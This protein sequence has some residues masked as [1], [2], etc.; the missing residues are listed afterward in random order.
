MAC[1]IGYLIAA[2]INTPAQEPASLSSGKEAAPEIMDDQAMLNSF[3]REAI[4]LKDQGKTVKITQLAR[5]LETCKTS[6]EVAIRVSS[7]GRTLTGEEIFDQCKKGVVVV[8]RLYKCPT[9][10]KFEINAASGIVLSESG[11]IATNRHVISAAN[12]PDPETVLIRTWEGNVFPIKE[13]LASDQKTDLALLQ[14]DGSGFSPLPLA[15]ELPSPGAAVYVI[16]H[17]EKHFYEMTAGIVSRHFMK[18]TAGNIKT[19]RM[20]IT[21]DFGGGSSGAPILDASGRVVGM[22]EA[23]HAVITKPVAPAKTET[24]GKGTKEEKTTP[25]AGGEKKVKEAPH[26]QDPYAQMII[27]ECIPVSAILELTGYRAGN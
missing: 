13:V 25:E 17:P 4:K 5:Q 1:A 6:H 18:T 8:G 21:A 3:A 12:L 24:P 22:V 9:C 2:N 14:A 15:K 23:T 10:K 16:S 19:P 27:K 20:A 11:V 7:S 26:P